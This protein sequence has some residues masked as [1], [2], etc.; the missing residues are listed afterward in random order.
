MNTSVKVEIK[1]EICR[2]KALQ[3]K[4]E[5][6]KKILLKKD[7]DAMVKKSYREV[8]AQDLSYKSMTELKKS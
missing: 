5:Q 6:L 3:K 2:I 4:I 8:A 7:L 1:D